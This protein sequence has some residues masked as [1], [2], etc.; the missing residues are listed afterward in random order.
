M[1]DMKLLTEEEQE[2]V[3]G[4]RI[5]FKPGEPK[6]LADGLALAGKLASGLATG[7]LVGTLGSALRNTIDGI[8]FGKGPGDTKHQ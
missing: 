5:H 3:T 2:N 4:G 7:D 6:S 8:S 1:E